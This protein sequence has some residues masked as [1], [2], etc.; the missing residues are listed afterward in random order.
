M[1]GR[2]QKL[3]LPAKITLRRGN[4]LDAQPNMIKTSPLLWG[5]F[6]LLMPLLANASDHS[7]V[8]AIL[9]AVEA[10]VHEQGRDLP[11]RVSIKSSRLDS[12]RTH[13]SCQQLE[14]FL[15]VGGRVW[16]RFSVGIRCL[17]A[18]GWTL[19]VPVEIEVIA[20]I[21]HAARPIRKGK[22]VRS[23]D[24]SMHETDLV[25]L[26]QDILND[27]EQAVGKMA[28]SSIAAGQP[29]RQRHLRAPHVITRGQKVQLT[30]TGP[31]F[32]V[33]TEG[34]ALTSAAS[35]EM[36]QVR[37]SA[38]RIISGIARADGSVEVRP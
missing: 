13:Q 36:V 9:E 2:R 22:L 33:S 8:S 10:F 23:D 28:T 31:G 35:G 24:I 18:S 5:L 15:P 3:P 20:P 29:L 1:Q 6:C 37:N 27:A 11:G 14:A 12:R 21:A 16:G 30:V 26:P 7:P 25:R 19:Y 17:D 32:T 34:D 38:G 4:N